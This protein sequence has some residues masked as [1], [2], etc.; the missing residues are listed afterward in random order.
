MTEFRQWLSALA[1]GMMGMAALGGLCLGTVARAD[2]GYDWKLP[3]WAPRPLV[4]ADNPMSA[5]KAELGR[6]LFY[7][8]RMSADGSQSCASCHVQS[9]AFTDGRSLPTGVTGEPGVR[10]AM[11]LTNVAYLPVLTWANPNQKR[12]ETQS[13]LPIFGEHPVEMGMA[14]KEGELFARLKADDQY[15]ALFDAAF[16]ETKGEISLSTI[17]KSLAAFERTLLS[18]DSPYDRYKYGGQSGAISE[19]AKRGETLFFSEKLECDHCHGGV[20]FTDNFQHARLAF[21]ELGFHNTGL[22]NM[23]GKGGYPAKNH[24]IRE[25]TG[26]PADEGKMRTPTLRNIALTAPYMHDGSVNTLTEAIRDHYARKGRARG[27][28]GGG[29]HGPSPLRDQFI[30]GFEITE[31]E[32]AD[33]VAFLET[34]T[35]KGF[36]TNPRFS[37]PFSKV[38]ELADR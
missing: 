7:D 29:G 14:G 3:D 17:T 5:A 9:R 1:T 6:R 38:R 19:A 16:P 18:F 2:D 24:G 35:D 21:P 25:V 8:K 23:D 36:T 15:P 28:A 32:T 13:L 33:L 26:D 4:P 12:L 30:E 11:S 22:Y 37:D 20:N 10:S 34:L 27:G 31:Q